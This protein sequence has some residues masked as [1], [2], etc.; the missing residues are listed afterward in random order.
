MTKAG[1][2]SCELPL[3]ATE[4]EKEVIQEVSVGLTATEAPATVAGLNGIFAFKEGQR[5]EAM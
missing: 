2:S 3:K 1:C 5:I 4:E